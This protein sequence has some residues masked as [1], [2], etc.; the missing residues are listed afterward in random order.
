LLCD[1]AAARDAV[2]VDDLPIIGGWP[3]SLA[4]DLDRFITTDARRSMRGWAVAAGA[5]SIAAPAIANINAPG[6]LE[7]L[8]H[9]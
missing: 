1:L 9:G 3:A 6:D 4:P 8:D 7:Q 2:I 5:R